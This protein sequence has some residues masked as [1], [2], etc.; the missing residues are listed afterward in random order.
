MRSKISI[1]AI[2]LNIFTLAYSQ[3]D[4]VQG[5]IVTT[6]FDTINGLIKLQ[7][8]HLNSISCIFMRPGDAV[9]KTYFPQELI[10]YKITDRK[11]YVSGEVT[12]DSVT[13]RLFLEYLVHGI[14][15]LYYLKEQ[16]Q[17]YF[18]LDKDNRMIQLNNDGRF[19]TRIENEGKRDEKIR[20][21][22]QPSLQYIRMLTVLFQDSPETLRELPK[23]NYDYKSLIAIAVDYH[24]AV[25]KDFD[26]INY[27]KSTNRHIYIEPWAGYELEWMGLKKSH[28]IASDRSIIAGASLRI[29]PFKGYSC[30]DLLVGLGYSHSTFSKDF[31][32]TL[33]EARTAGYVMIFR[34]YA[35][36]SM[37]QFPITAE[38]TYPSRNVRPFFS[39]SFVTGYVPD[40]KFSIQR[41]D[42]YQGPDLDRFVKAQFS[43][44]AGLGV[45]FQL[46]NGSYLNLK[47]E[48]EYRKAARKSGW[49]FDNT[50]EYTWR[51][52]L[53]YGIMLK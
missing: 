52:S 47:N 6:D 51:F 44:M 17:E 24:N 48:I 26:C 36:Y 11:Y 40:P 34:T 35:S 38:Y 42:Q 21:F 12:V 1:V 53:G 9:P 10:S 46:K 14:A 13:K 5:F 31:H 19:I 32:T 4:F 3:K 49:L 25:C 33:F 45:R 8:D 22:Y 28:D 30:W 50:H 15:D 43:G 23:L 2:L 39:L 29:K 16:G 37:F 20:T 41:L 7:P 18:F 27:T